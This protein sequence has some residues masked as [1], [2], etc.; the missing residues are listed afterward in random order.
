MD[1]RGLAALPTVTGA[2][3]RPNREV[4]DFIEVYLH[5]DGYQSVDSQGGPTMSEI[6][7]TKLDDGHG[8]ENPPQVKPEEPKDAKPDDGHGEENPPQVKPDN[9]VEP[10]DAKPDADMGRKR[11]LHRAN[12]RAWHLKWVSKGVPR[13]SIPPAAAAKGPA[14]AGT[15]SEASSS[16]Q[17]ASS[18]ARAREKFISEWIEASGMPKSQERF[19]A[20]CKAWMESTT[21]ADFMST[22]AG[23]QR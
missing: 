20:A 1:P 13:Q 2:S 22:R 17:T 9:T 19:K 16:C 6:P 21:R 12:S 11:A 3:L 18:M 14:R 23:V 5:D 15:G 10:K 7:N 4:K 8:E